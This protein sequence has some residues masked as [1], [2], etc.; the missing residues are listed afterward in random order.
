MPSHPIRSAAEDGG[1]KRQ[2][3]GKKAADLNGYKRREGEVRL[4]LF[5]PAAMRPKAFGR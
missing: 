5:R 3:Y 2:R 1:R 4:H